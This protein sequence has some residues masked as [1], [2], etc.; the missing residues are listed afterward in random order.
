MRRI[1]VLFARFSSF[2]LVVALCLTFG[3]TSASANPIVID[4]NSAPATQ[5]VFSYS[6]DGFTLDPNGYHFHF[7]YLDNPAV[8]QNGSIA[9]WNHDAELTLARPDNRA[10]SFMAFDAGE[11]MSSQ[12]SRGQ[13]SN[14]RFLSTRIS[15]RRRGCFGHIYARWFRRWKPRSSR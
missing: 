11:I 9:L 7:N 13:D 10:F 12:D 4:F 5:A 14:A 8:S 6:E 1:T 15:D 2:G 3:S